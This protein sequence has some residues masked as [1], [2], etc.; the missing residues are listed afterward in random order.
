MPKNAIIGAGIMGM[1]LSTVLRDAGQEAELWDIVPGKVENQKHLSHV[2]EDAECIFYCVPSWRLEEAVAETLPLLPQDAIGV[3]IS[4]GLD[5]ASGNFMPVFLHTLGIRR[6]VLLSGPMLGVELSEG[7]RGYGWA[8]SEDKRAADAVAARFRGSRLIVESSGEPESTALAGVL[9]NLYAIVLGMAVGSGY[10][11]KNDLGRFFVF[12]LS[13]MEAVAGRLDCD[14][15]VMRAVP[16]LGDLVATGLSEHSQNFQLGFELGASGRTDR[17]SEG[18]MSFSALR[19]RIG[20][21]SPFLLLS[22]LEAV[23][24]GKRTPKEALDTLFS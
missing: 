13:E 8:A 9:K 4:K 20:D 6:P 24:K 15:S 21:L 18:S 19:E 2:L 10:A 16:G 23:L 5:Q 17:Q 3:T 1:A 11:C 14:A 12:A 7:G 22:V